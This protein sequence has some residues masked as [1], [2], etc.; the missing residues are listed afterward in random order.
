MYCIS[1]NTNTLL[2][3]SQHFK[4]LKRTLTEPLK[5]LHVFLLYVEN[6][7]H[8][9]VCIQKKM[10]ESYSQTL[11]NSNTVMIATVDNSVKEE[12]YFP[13]SLLSQMTV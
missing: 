2:D 6:W 13:M 8:V 1:R 3:T 11:K 9:K 7:C 10:I 12:L 4:K 5:D